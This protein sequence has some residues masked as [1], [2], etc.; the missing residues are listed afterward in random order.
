MFGGMCSYAP[1]TVD[2]MERTASHSPVSLDSSKSGAAP[3][4]SLQCIIAQLTYCLQYNLGNALACTLLLSA[5]H[6]SVQRCSATEL[7]LKTELPSPTELASSEL[8]TLDIGGCCLVEDL[9]LLLF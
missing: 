5:I 8:A 4:S 7:S 6:L 1:A 3:S 2:I 9:L